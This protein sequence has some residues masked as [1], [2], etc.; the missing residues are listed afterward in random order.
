MLLGNHE[1]KT[2]LKIILRCYLPLSLSFF[3][4]CT[5][6]FSRS[7]VTCDDVITLAAM[8]SVCFKNLS[9]LI[10][11]F[12]NMI[13]VIQIHKSSLGSSIIFSSVKGS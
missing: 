11:S 10:S 6:E 7:Y 5:V 1:V 2:I 13:D 4:G 3:H 8:G 12:L 9:V